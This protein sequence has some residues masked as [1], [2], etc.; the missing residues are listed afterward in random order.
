MFN[1]PFAASAVSASRKRSQRDSDPVGQ[2][3]AL[4]KSPLKLLPGA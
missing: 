4:F 2:Q 1:V 3:K